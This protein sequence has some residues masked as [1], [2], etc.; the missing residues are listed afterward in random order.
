MPNQLR[1][2]LSKF[3][4]DRAYLVGRPRVLRIA[5]LLVSWIFSTTHFAWPSALKY[6]LLRLFA[7]SIGRSVL[8]RQDVY[9]HLP[10]NLALADSVWIGH[11]CVLLNFEHINIGPNSA[12][13]HDSVSSC[14]WTRR[15]GS[16]HGL[17]AQ[18]DHH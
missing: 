16:P 13:S 1:V 15:S 11:G 14:C 6:L 17:P 4:A 3:V 7:T 5:W 12:L 2:D 10:W 9:I 18:V 8:I